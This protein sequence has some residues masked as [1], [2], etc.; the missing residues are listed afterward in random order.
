MPRAH[1]SILPLLLWILSFFPDLNFCVRISFCVRA[2]GA[3]CFLHVLILYDHNYFSLTHLLE[4]LIRAQNISIIYIYCFDFEKTKKTT[5]KHDSHDELLNYYG[6]RWRTK[7]R[8]ILVIFSLFISTG[9]L[10][11]EVSMLLVHD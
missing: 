11:N 7:F 9:F 4:T 6:Q 1:K 8:W 10:C 2:V 3:S 5:K